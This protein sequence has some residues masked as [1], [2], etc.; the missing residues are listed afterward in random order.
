MPRDSTDRSWSSAARSARPRKKPWRT[1]GPIERSSKTCWHA[2]GRR[3]G[4]PFG[5]RV[6]GGRMNRRFLA[7]LLTLA[8]VVSGDA[9]GSGRAPLATAARDRTDLSDGWTPPV[10]PDGHSN[11]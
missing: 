7:V 8:A 4:E 10:G 9:S 6:T 11:L 3:S 1:R 5:E 2:W